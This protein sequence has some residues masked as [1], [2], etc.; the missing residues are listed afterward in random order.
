MLVDRPARQL[1]R[2]HKLSGS[3]RALDRKVRLPGLE[4][5]S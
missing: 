5:T 4:L 1:D 2:T 3:S